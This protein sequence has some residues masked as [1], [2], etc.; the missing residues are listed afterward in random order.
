ML[1]KEKSQL[2]PPFQRAGGRC[3]PAGAFGIPPFELKGPAPRCAVKAAEHIGNLGGTAELSVPLWA[4]GLFY[5]AGSPAA[6]ILRLSDKKFC[7]R[8][9]VQFC[10]FFCIGDCLRNNFHTVDLFC[11][12]G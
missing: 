7:I 11:P 10:I 4:G 1:T 9:T 6:D 12:L 5:Y 8:N 2:Y 3:E